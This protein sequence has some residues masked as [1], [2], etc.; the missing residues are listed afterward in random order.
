V[1]NFPVLPQGLAL[2]TWYRVLS[3][4]ARVDF[5][6][7]LYPMVLPAVGAEPDPVPP[8]AGELP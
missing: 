3:A 5:I 2:S 6:G 8:V 4:D 1:K 7:G